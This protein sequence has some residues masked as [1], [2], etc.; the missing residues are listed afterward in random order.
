ME[1]SSDPGGGLVYITISWLSGV[2]N[3]L[4]A[5]Y[6]PDQRPLQLHPTEQGRIVHRS[7]LKNE[8]EKNIIFIYFFYFKD[9]ICI[10]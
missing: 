8:D 4:S 5:I 9:F 3:C 10:Y 2:G 7:G 1:L 6:R